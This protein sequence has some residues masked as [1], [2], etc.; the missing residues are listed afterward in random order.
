MRQDRPVLTVFPDE[1]AEQIGRRLGPVANDVD[2]L[3][4]QDCYDI[5]PRTLARFVDTV[6]AY[7]A[8]GYRPTLVGG[9]LLVERK[10]EEVLGWMQMEAVLNDALADVDAHLVCCYPRTGQPAWAYGAALATH[11]RVLVDGAASRNASYVDPPAFLASHPEPAP[12]PLRTPS[13]AFRFGGRDLRTIRRLVEQQG[14]QAGLPEE[15]QEELVLA[16]NEAASNTLEHGPGSGTV[17]FWINDNGITCEVHDTGQFD[18]PHL[19]LLPP[20]PTSVRGRGLWLIRQLPDRTCLW[21]NDTGTTIR[22]TM[23]I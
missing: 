13:T 20:T 6:H 5:A 12:A 2:T 11:P 23:Y 16:V 1:L 22:M 10:P 14:A 19:G 4:Y 7:C 15:R 9:P 18:Q 8:A 21:Q 3:P 17:K